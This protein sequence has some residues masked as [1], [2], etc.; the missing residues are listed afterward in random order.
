MCGI[1][2][3]IGF[4]VELWGKQMRSI[5]HRGPDDS[6]S[7]L[8]FPNISFGH[9]RLSILDL[10]ET[11]RQ[12][13]TTYRYVLTY[14]G[15]IYN[16][17]EFYRGPLNDAGALLELIER[18]GPI[19]ALEYL[20]G[21]FAFAVYDRQENKLYLAVDRFGQKPL[22]YYE[23]GEGFAFASTPAALTHLRSSWELD[24]DALQTYW[25]M[26]AV[27]SDCSLFD[28]IKKLLAAHVLIY[29][30]GKKTIQI[31]RYWSPGLGS[32]TIRD[33][34]DLLAQA[35]T[36][37][38]LSD[39]PISLLLS[40][41]I[42][43]S[44]IAT[45]C[46]GIKA[47]HLESP[48][49]EYAQLVAQK[50]SIDLHLV[51][52]GAVWVERELTDLAQTSGVP[53]MAGLIPYITAQAVSKMSKVGISAYGAD[54][55]F[56]G[57]NRTQDRHHSE[58]IQ[59]I[60]RRR[61]DLNFYRKHWDIDNEAG[62]RM[63]ELYSFIQFDLNQTLDFAAM[64]HGVEV[65]NPYLDHELVEA[66]LSLPY[67]E[68]VTRRYGNKAIL[69]SILS[70]AGFDNSFLTRPKIGFS[71]HKEPGDMD[72]HRRTAVNWCV[73]NKFLD[74]G[75][76]ELTGLFGGRNRRYLE[77]SALSFYYWCKFWNFKLNNL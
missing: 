35:I 32:Y 29:D 63:L 72:I 57:Y 47:F 30:V 44:I 19:K 33:V 25:E 39:V 31:S 51:E 75:K 52:T 73:E 12:P 67:S 21:M 49:Y 48:E 9:T 22:Y 42:D 50:Y 77:A 54:E 68:H 20:N 43:S 55:L 69:K 76:F 23:N 36:R 62:G 17:K 1:V 41:G 10:S 11:G 37:V 7:I 56:F 66:A 27:A 61:V 64:A 38:K 16:Y 34:E 40:G 65:R 2:G 45:M 26:G 5:A 8:I 6:G 70:R 59:H 18:Y 53:C 3:N 74:L 60:F 4:D 13:M 14:N 24:R 28:G 71:L 15:E 58:Q 46:A